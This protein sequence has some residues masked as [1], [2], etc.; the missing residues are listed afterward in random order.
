MLKE[1]HTL[2]ILYMIFASFSSFFLFRLSR[3]R[4]AVRI[5]GRTSF[6][7]HA[8]GIFLCGIGTV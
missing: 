8:R 4:I 2:R 1:K 5:A 3:F 7:A 6:F